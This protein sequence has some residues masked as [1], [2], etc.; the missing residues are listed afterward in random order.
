MDKGRARQRLGTVQVLAAAA[1]LVLVVALAGCGGG[2]GGAVG[3][4]APK[5]AASAPASSTTSTTVKPAFVPKVTLT[6]T[7]K[8]PNTGDTE[9]GTLKVGQLTPAD[10]AVTLPSGRS[11]AGVL[12]CQ[13]DRQ[14]DLI[15][16]ATL[17]VRNDNNGFNQNVAAHLYAFVARGGLL[18]AIGKPL[19]L[20]DVVY[21]Q[22]GPTCTSVVTYSDAVSQYGSAFGLTRAQTPPG[23]SAHAEFFIIVPGVRTPGA[24]LG[25]RS[26][27]DQNGIAVRPGLV[28]Q[29]LTDCSAGIGPSAPCSVAFGSLV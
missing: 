17:D 12:T 29:Q 9:T 5:T 14:R 23:E 8:M 13:V 24:P 25:D 11:S 3:L 1:A 22:G 26:F 18:G 16:P 6:F 4:K 7:E 27:L 21:S 2:S 20:A 28:A 15:A 19:Y 10:Q